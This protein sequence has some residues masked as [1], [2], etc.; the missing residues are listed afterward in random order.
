MNTDLKLNQVRFEQKGKNS[1]FELSAIDDDNN[2]LCNWLAHRMKYDTYLFYCKEHWNF[3]S[4]AYQKVYDIIFLNDNIRIGN[5]STFCD[6]NYWKSDIFETNFKKFI[7]MCISNNFNLL[8]FKLESE[9]N[10]NLKREGRYTTPELERL[11]VE[12]VTKLLGKYGFEKISQNNDVS[13]WIL[14]LT[15]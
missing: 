11:R 10:K 1:I 4:S 15:K 8:S 12:T 9:S 7:K 14:D 2:T 13:I 3:D 5:I 6:E